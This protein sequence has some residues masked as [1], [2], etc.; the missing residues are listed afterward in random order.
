MVENT[1]VLS[2]VTTLSECRS[3][4][5]SMVLRSSIETRLVLFAYEAIEL[6]QVLRHLLGV[7]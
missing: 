7:L 3:L 6:E 4:R 1:H 5:F 2:A